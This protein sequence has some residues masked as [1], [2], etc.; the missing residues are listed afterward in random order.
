MKLLGKPALREFVDKHADAGSQI[1]S[2][3]AEV[4]TAKWKTPI[5][6]KQRYPKASLIGNQQVVFNICGNRYRLWVSVAY[7]TGIVVVK[8]VGTHKEYDEWE[9]E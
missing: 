1:E 3:E 8:K 4:E 2:W 7:Q 9:I 6:L 5:D